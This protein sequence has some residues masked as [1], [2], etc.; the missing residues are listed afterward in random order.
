MGNV[1]LV[2]LLCHLA[3][4][5]LQSVLFIVS[6]AEKN[7]QYL[8]FY[9]LLNM[10]HIAPKSSTNVIYLTPNIIIRLKSESIEAVSFLYPH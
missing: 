7:L 1:N 8:Q 6:T 10:L 2:S 3:A 9:A 4:A 5:T